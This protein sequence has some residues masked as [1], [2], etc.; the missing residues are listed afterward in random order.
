MSHSHQGPP[1]SANPQTEKNDTQQLFV[2]LQARKALAMSPANRPVTFADILH[3]V[4][5]NHHIDV[6]RVS[7]AINSDLSQRRLYQKLLNENRLAFGP[8][9]AHA[10]DNQVIALRRGQGFEIKLRISRTR[11]EQVYVILQ[12][13]Y[14]DKFAANKA[15]VLHICGDDGQSRLDFP[16]L[17]EGKSQLIMLQDDARLAALRADTELSL[18]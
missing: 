2:A 6:D 7:R 5:G 1:E 17:V 16:A 18:L 15:L 11:T 10:Q 8:R 9:E 3:Y 14:P 13:E 4:L 12:V